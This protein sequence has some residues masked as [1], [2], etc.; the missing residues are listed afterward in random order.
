MAKQD[1]KPK[2]RKGKRRLGNSYRVLERRSPEYQRALDFFESNNRGLAT[3]EASLILNDALSTREQVH[4]IQELERKNRYECILY[5][6]EKQTSVKQ[7]VIE[8]AL[9]GLNG[10]SLYHEQMFKLCQ[11]HGMT[12]L[13]SGTCTFLFD[14]VSNA[15]EA[16]SLMHELKQYGMHTS[17]QVWNAAIH[18]CKTDW[19]MAVNLFRECKRNGVTPNERTYRQ[20]M[21]AC[22]KSGPVRITL[23]LL[24]ELQSRENIEVSP[25]I[26]GTALG[27][28]AKTG[29]RE[30]AI[31]ILIQMQIQKV[32]INII[33]VSA[34]LST[35][36]RDGRDDIALELLE[37]FRQEKPFYLSEYN[38]TIPSAPLDLLAINIVLAACAKARNYGDARQI[39]EQIKA[40]HYAGIESP[41][42][43]SYNTLLSACADPVQAK[44]IVKEVC[45]CD[46]CLYGSVF[47]TILTC[48]R[49]I[50]QMRMSRRH[51]Y[52]AVPPTSITYTHA[53]SACRRNSDIESALF[54]LELARND[55]IAPNVYMYSAAI[56]CCGC[57][58]DKALEL[59]EEMRTSGCT[60]N[61][62][63][64][65]GV[66]SALSLQG[67]SEEALSLFEELKDDNLK[68]I[69]LTFQVRIVSYRRREWFNQRTLTQSDSYCSLRYACRN[70][71][72]RFVGQLKT[73]LGQKCS[74]TF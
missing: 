8:A 48:Y 58:G 2:N 61:V 41:D 38:L 52:G 5:L 23:S 28:C 19:Q 31:S 25:A 64:Y 73:L 6:I 20:V 63:S 40:G 34:L 55:G 37:C 44:A 22:A 30:D 72:L 14:Q 62:V 7:Q 54:F 29:T 32:P 59:L 65:N 49:Y 18:A 60:P 43:F 33:H 3:E 4:L 21:K 66:L 24:E 45:V 71:P 35:C 68:P 10:N 15:T 50:M 13:S 39:L 12:S 42:V 26:L 53:I 70:L 17:I 36:A 57:D 9:V 69:R 46:T 56:W 16:V 51:R 27:S 47:F 1:Y 74:S 11:Q 67:R